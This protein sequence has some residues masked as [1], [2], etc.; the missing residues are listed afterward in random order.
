MAN[1][2]EGVRRL[3]VDCGFREAPWPPRGVRRWSVIGRTVEGG[4]EIRVAC[5]S[6]GGSFGLRVAPASARDWIAGLLVHNGVHGVSVHADP[7]GAGGRTRRPWIAV[8]V[9]IGALALF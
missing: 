1:D 3:L 8:G 6:A 9:G 2:S 7:N 5:V 4:P